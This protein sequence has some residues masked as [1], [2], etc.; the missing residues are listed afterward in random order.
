MKTRHILNIGHPRCATTWLWHNLI[1]HPSMDKAIYHK[2]NQILFTASCFQDYIDFYSRFDNSANFNPNI[3]IIDRELISFLAPHVTHISAIL[4]NPYDFLERYYDF[5]GNHHSHDSF[6]QW[7]LEYRI[8]DYKYIFERWRDAIG[9]DSKLQIFFF[10]DIKKDPKLFLEKYFA[11]CDLPAI[12]DA[13]FAKA[14]NISMSSRS[15]IDFTDY[16]KIINDKIKTFGDQI[17]A[18]LTDW[19]R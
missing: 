17:N 2:E 4:R 19:L 3:W 8:I 16:K 1:Q 12:L 11:F 15:V 18:D 13:N 7:A 9:C 6:V 5:A 10:D 14:K